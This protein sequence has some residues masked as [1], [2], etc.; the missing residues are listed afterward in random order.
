MM[1]EV[2]TEEAIFDMEFCHVQVNITSR[3]NM[4]CEHCRGA[5]SDFKDVD[6]AVEDFQALAEFSCRH[7]SDGCGF[8]ISGGEPLLHPRFN[9]IIRA[10]K[11][12]VKKSA[13]LSLTTNG[14]ILN[15]R[16]LEML[17][18]LEFPEVRVSISLD[19]VDSVR[20]NAFRHH[21]RAFKNA[22]R[23]IKLASS[24]DGIKCLV[25]ASIQKD[26]L[27]EVEKLADLAEAHGAK[28]LSIASI[29]PV[30][31]ALKR[32]CLYFDRDT[33]KELIEMV[34]TL[35]KRHTGIMIDVN[36][37][38]AYVAN[39]KTGEEG[40]YG[41]CIAGIGTFS[42]EPDG[43]MLP[44][45]VLPNQA[46][47]NIIGKTP[48]EMTREFSQST[49]VRALVGRKLKGK[50]G[51]CKLRFTCG[52]CRARAPNGTGVTTSMKIRTAGSNGDTGG[53]PS[54]LTAIFFANSE[55]QSL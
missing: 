33:K 22:L 8:L 53:K 46:I 51:S 2:E 16:H 27:G 37:P 15:T 28:V 36:D 43:S 23:A 54:G 49:F 55:L 10:L 30:G 40:E 34:A 29:I 35:R 12:H 31:N 14:L 17:K 11:K 38:L 39:M 3:C 25:R 7:M 52:G 47:M 20:H 18:S 44:C 32:S 24:T 45:P 1:F 48:D 41:G 19:S 50:C 42:V 13:F 26:Q 5:Y 6:L 9:D 21:P 4:R